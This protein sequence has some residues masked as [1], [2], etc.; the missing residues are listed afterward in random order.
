MATSSRRKTAHTPEKPKR[1]EWFEQNLALAR[2]G[3][4]AAIHILWVEYQ[5]DYAKEG[6]GNG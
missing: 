3:N 4:E 1:D 6:H 2:E 5:Y